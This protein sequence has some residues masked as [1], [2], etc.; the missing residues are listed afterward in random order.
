MKRRLS[1]SLDEEV[2]RQIDSFVDG[3]VVKSRSEAIERFLREHLTDRKTAVILAGGKPEDLYIE[4]LGVYRPLVKINGKRLVEYLVLK[5]R[6]AGY[7]NQ[8]VVGHSKV[9]SK[10]YEILGNGKNY[11]VNI[12]YVED[13]KPMGSAK[14]LERAKPYLKSDFLLLPCDHY[15]DFDLKKIRDF[16]VENGGAVTLAIHTRADYSWRYGVVELD[17]KRIVNYDE[18]PKKPKTSLYSTLIGFF[19]PEVFDHIPPGDV[20]WSLQENVFN[21]LAKEGKMFGYPTSGR[22]FNIHT[23]ED[24]ERVRLSTSS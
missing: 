15:F 12:I 13:D 23:K 21:K 8:I 3:I 19:S 1:I 17:G 20:K 24:V 11:D 22:W 14:T 9:I 2:V 6:E 16:H 5:A 10:I 18:K 4:E 7:H